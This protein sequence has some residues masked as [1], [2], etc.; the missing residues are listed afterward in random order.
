MSIVENNNTSYID[1]LLVGLFYSGSV[2]Y[3]KL[4]ESNQ[5]DDRFG[6]LQEKIKYNFIEKL[7]KNIS[8]SFENI[9]NIRNYLVFYTNMK[10]TKQYDSKES[11][12]LCECDVSCLYDFLVRNLSDCPIIDFPNI[13]N[14]RKQIYTININLDNF[15]NSITSIND[16]ISDWKKENNIIRISNIP[17]VIG[18]KIDRSKKSPLIDISEKIRLNNKSDDLGNIKW[19]IHSVICMSKMHYYT[20]FINVYKWYIFDNNNI[21]CIKEVNMSD[22]SLIKKIKSESV[23]IIYQYSL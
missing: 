11:E 6:Y 23:F 16:L 4:L 5:K 15:K 1:S 3:S 21:P 9:N 10:I 14:E 17:F 13:S 7:K 19:T 18:I 8:V 22:T 2:I 20:L 12:L